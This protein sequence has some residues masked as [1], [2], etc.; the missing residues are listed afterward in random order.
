MPDPISIPSI[1]W[2]TIDA[3]NK[4]EKAQISLRSMTPS[5][6]GEAAAQSKEACS[7]LESLFIYYLFKEMRATIPKSGL[8]SGGIAEDVYTSMLD[9]QLAKELAFKGGIGI[10]PLLFDQLVGKPERGS[11]SPSE[12]GQPL[13]GES[14]EG[15]AE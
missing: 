1:P 4:I 2:Q 5:A 9:Q 7:E 14:D 11:P 10:S 6:R 3:S 13:Q 8:I 15:Q 12:A